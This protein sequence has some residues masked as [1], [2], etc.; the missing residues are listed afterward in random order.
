MGK[1]TTFAKNNRFKM[2]ILTTISGIIIGAF[3]WYELR[4][5][6]IRSSCSE[7][8]K[9]LVSSKTLS[10]N[11]SIRLFLDLCLLNSGLKK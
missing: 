2:I 3:C 6:L 1:I 9:N 7:K 11:E 4:P 5:M 8:I 10:S